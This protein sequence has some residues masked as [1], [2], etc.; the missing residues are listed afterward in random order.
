[1]RWVPIWLAIFATSV[2]LWTFTW[3]GELA[4]WRGK[5]PYSSDTCSWY[6]A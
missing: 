3:S 6:H 2:M 4:Y 5:Y 1:M